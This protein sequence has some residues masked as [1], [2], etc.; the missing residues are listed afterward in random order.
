MRQREHS[1]RLGKRQ[2]CLRVP[3][4]RG[5][6]MDRVRATLALGGPDGKTV[7]VTGIEHTWLVTFRVERPG[8]AWQRARR[9]KCLPLATGQEAATLAGGAK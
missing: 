6:I 2:A 9:S 7:H 3:L 4:G 8:L 5:G 1:V